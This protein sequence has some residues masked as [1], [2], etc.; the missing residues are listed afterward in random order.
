[1]EMGKVKTDK[2]TVSV[3]QQFCLKI[4]FWINFDESMSENGNFP[5]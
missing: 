2:L 1:M 4:I 3:A 5:G